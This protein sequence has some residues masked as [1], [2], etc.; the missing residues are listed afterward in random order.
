MASLLPEPDD[1]D[2]P[3]LTVHY[4]VDEAGT[5][6]LFNAKGKVIVGQAG[7]SSFFFLGKLD[8]QEPAAPPCASINDLDL[9]LEMAALA[10]LR[11]GVT[12]WGR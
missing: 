3:P 11:R 4:F 7:C 1:D 2:E 6:T 12:L 8:V 10:V 5:P 9:R